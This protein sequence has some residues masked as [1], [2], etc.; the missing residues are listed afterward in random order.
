MIEVP[1]VL[2]ADVFEQQVVTQG[3]RHLDDADW[4]VRFHAGERAVID[5]CYRR[6]ARMVRD[7][8]AHIVAPVD[9]ETIVHEIFFS[10][11]SDAR[12][13]TSFRG[14]SLHAWLRRVARNRAIDLQRKRKREHLADP[15][16]LDALSED[17]PQ[18]D[19]FLEA[20]ARRIVGRFRETALPPKLA[21]VFETRV[22][23]ALSQREAARRLGMSR[24][25]LALRERR[26]LKLLERFVLHGQGG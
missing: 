21:G 20:E 4:L 7:V 2:P 19:D 26:V 8:A 16:A 11:L 12:V 5:Q 22:V 3:D 1:D 24:T 23:S 6:Y 18:S 15:A 9:A 25:T 13:R 17:V 14:G 10:L